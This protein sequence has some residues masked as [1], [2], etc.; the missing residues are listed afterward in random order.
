MSEYYF[1]PG[2]IFFEVVPDRCI[3]VASGS[4][5][6]FLR[7]IYRLGNLANDAI[8]N[9]KI[10][11]FINYILVLIKLEIYIYNNLLVYLI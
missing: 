3:S 2:I 6:K 5:L 7:Q 1:D 10:W 4:N 8:H 11:E 9:L